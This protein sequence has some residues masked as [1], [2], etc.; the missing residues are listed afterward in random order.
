[1]TVNL[2]GVTNAQTLT[3]TLSSVTDRFSQVLA[4]T[5]L[6]VSMLVGDTTANG[7]VN[8]SD[9]TQTKRRSGG[10]VTINNFRSDVNANGV[11]NGSDVAIVKA[12]SG[13]SVGTAK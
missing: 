4:D 8:A 5:P 7:I 6:R 1:M 13:G 10:P 12:H 11:I 3:V 2:T 9:V